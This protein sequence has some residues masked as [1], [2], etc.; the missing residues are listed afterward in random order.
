MAAVELSYD[1]DWARFRTSFFWS[2]G[3]HN[4]NNSH[5]TGFD[6]IF[7][8]PNFAGGGFSFWQR[9]GIGLFGVNLTNRESLIPDL[10]PSKIQGQ[11]NHVNPGLLLFNLG[12]DFDI[13]PRLKTIINTNFLWFESTK[14][15]ETFLFDGNIAHKIG[16]DLSLGILY[17]PL[18]SQN[19][20]FTAGVSTLIPGDGFQALYD[21]KKDTIDPLV[22]SFFQAVL[23]Y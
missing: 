4:P 19:V 1:R 3:D 15:L 18:A 9:Q 10:R 2:S 14:V 21:N 22:A 7:D 12:V 20:Q 13:T 11:A 5:A 6:T 8:G 16:T 23:Q 17:R